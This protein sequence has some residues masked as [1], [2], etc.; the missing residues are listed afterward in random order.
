MAERVK[1]SLDHNDP[2]AAEQLGFL[3]MAYHAMELEEAALAAYENAHDLDPT[4]MRWPYYAC[5]L[6]RIRGE[7]NRAVG[8][9][10]SLLEKYPEDA[11]IWM[12]LGQI[13]LDGGDANLALECF[14][15]ATSLLPNQA[16]AW[17]GLAQAHGVLEHPELAV[18]S[19]L[20]ALE[21]QPQAST[22][23]YPLAQAYR[24]LGKTDE[25]NAHLLKR[26]DGKI[27]IPD[28][29]LSDLND[30]VTTM[31][32]QVTLAMA[33]ADV[34]VP[35]D[36]E[37]FVVAGLTERSGI[38][39]YLI[40]T[41]NQWH[42]QGAS[43]Q[44]ARL[45]YAAALIYQSRQ[46]PQLSSEQDRQACNYDPDL[47][48]AC[49]RH[50]QWLAQ[51]GESDEAL[52]LANRLI[53]AHPTDITLLNA[54][55]KMY[56]YLD[57]VQAEIQDLDRILKLDSEH[58]WA[59]EQMGSALLKQG[60]KQSANIYLEQALDLYTDPNDR[61]RVLELLIEN[62]VSLQRFDEALRF[63][64]QAL[65]LQPESSAQHYR[66]GS[67]LGT[68]RRYDEA[69]AAMRA[70]QALSPDQPDAFLGE[71]VALILDEQWLEATRVLDRSLEKWPAHTRLQL[72][73]ARIQIACPDST[74]RNIPN[75][76]LTVSHMLQKNASP[77]VRETYAFALAGQGL[78]AQ[79]AEEM[80]N[81]INSTEN[82][83]QKTVWQQ[84]YQ[85]F[86]TQS[87][88]E[89]LPTKWFVQP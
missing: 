75:A 63:Q 20:A 33:M 10:H 41:A 27:Q 15:K 36:F 80:T 55:A 11:W 52:R 7:L 85:S 28:P 84:I 19:Y 64:Q 18:Q 43:K 44:A 61:I 37:A 72:I 70:A 49:L 8:L 22:V 48:P 14:E 21:L 9:Y 82:Q 50:A 12:R 13:H 65:T 77:T 4:D 25:A 46:E 6:Y 24:K 30:T 34:F 42:A 86:A 47:V 88:Y 2:A 58:V 53:D 67:L 35:K 45:H 83:T 71:S 81:L 74:L 54:R 59:H 68:L 17:F 69:A 79:A 51:S 73:R 1:S 31:A 57:Q 38:V 66:M 40:A 89:E 76:F 39:E 62:L 60:N 78:F 56:Q 3:G 23:H 5:L 29:H 87:P 32:V 16:A 26:G